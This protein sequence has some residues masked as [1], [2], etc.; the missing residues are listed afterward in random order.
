MADEFY[1]FEEALRELNLKEEE[2]KRLVSEGEIRAF[3][4]GDTMKLRRADV[5]NLKGELLGGEVVDLGGVGEE[6]VFE[7]DLETQ[8]TGM[9][10][11]AITEVDTL[12]EAEVEDIGEVEELTEET[13]ATPIR[14]TGPRNTVP[15]GMLVRTLSIV[16]AAL[17]VLA[18]PV[19][20]SLSTGS[21]GD[22][23][24]AIADLFG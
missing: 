6:I 17:L 20:V 18:I 2:L 15:E 22:L 1:N 9:A 10:T 24:R 8:E 14:R 7:D 12:L 3:R 21:A 4:D 13:V 11:E 5:E 23:A 16:T 19:A